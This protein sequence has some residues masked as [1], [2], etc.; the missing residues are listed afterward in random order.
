MNESL[1][2]VRYGKALLELATEKKILDKVKKDLDLIHECIAGSKE[3]NIFLE[4]PLFKPF[5]KSRLVNEIFKGKIDKLSLDFF[6]LLIKNRREAF[7]PLI[8]L[9]FIDEYKLKQGIKEAFIYTADP[10]KKAHKQQILEYISKKLKLNIE[11]HDKVDPS[12]IGGFILRIEDQQINASL[13]SQLKK[14]KR[15]LI[16]S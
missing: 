9:Y 10:L 7:L 3:F 11:L 1:I 4:S 2:R 14:I 12:M 5:D 13:K 16:N 6:H 8:C 15:E